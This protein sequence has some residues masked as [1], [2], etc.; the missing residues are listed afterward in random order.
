MT[1]GSVEPSFVIDFDAVSIDGDE[2]EISAAGTSTAAME[3]IGGRGRH[4]RV[5]GMDRFGAGGCLDVYVQ[6]F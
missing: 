1:P 3:G 4:R 5:E 6:M 2:D